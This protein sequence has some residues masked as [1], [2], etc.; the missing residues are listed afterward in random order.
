MSKNTATVTKTIHV[1]LICLNDFKMS[2]P[3]LHP[4]YQPY[5]LVKFQNDRYSGLGVKTITNMV[6]W[7]VVVIKL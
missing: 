6:T 5:K 4:P 2:T 7:V 1:Y 3:S